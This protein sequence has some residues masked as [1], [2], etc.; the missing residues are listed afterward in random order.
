M[1]W[2]ALA[3]DETRMFAAAARQGLTHVLFARRQLE[4]QKFQRLA[5]TSARTRDCCLEK[6]YEDAHV[7]LYRL[8]LPNATDGSGPVD[9]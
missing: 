3:G 6:L 5:I 7:L 1:T 2:G 9:R 8:R 4:D